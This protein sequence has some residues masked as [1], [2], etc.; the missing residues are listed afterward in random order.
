[1]AGPRPAPR[2]WMLENN[3]KMVQLHTTRIVPETEAIR[4][5]TH[6]LAP[7]PKYFMMELWLT[8]TLITPAMKKAG[9]RHST[10]CSRAYQRARS[11][12]AKTAP[13]K[14]SESIGRKYAKRKTAI[15]Q[16]RF[17][18]SCFVSILRFFSRRRKCRCSKCPQAGKPQR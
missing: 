8:N 16:I 15:I 13:V 7:A 17:F 2:L 12:E 9:N 4:Y 11:S 18:I 5:A 6:F 10:T 1:M 3:G 14:A